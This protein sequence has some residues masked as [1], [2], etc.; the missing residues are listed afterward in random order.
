MSFAMG[1]QPS[2]WGTAANTLPHSPTP[3]STNGSSFY[4]QPLDDL[5]QKAVVRASEGTVNLEQLTDNNSE[6]NATFDQERPSA[7][8]QFKTE[9][10]RI[11]RYT[12]TSSGARNTSDPKSWT[13]WASDDGIHWGQIDRR[14]NQT[15]AWRSMT[16]AY[17]IKNPN[18]YAY[19]KITVDQKSSNHPLA[20]SEFQ[21]LGYSGITKG[22][23]SL[24]RELE[25][26]YEL[27]NVTEAEWDHLIRILDQ[28]QSAYKDGNL[29]ASISSMQA[30]VQQINSLLYQ[31][32]ASEKGSG[33][34]LADA[35]AIVNLLSD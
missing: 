2:S 28:A 21:L 32:N 24:K 20:L 16:R 19:Y 14:T 7:R 8:F 1:A 5:S 29:S 35:H 30:A 33:L 6:T 10:P 9:S 12:L 25:H 27:K 26:Q 31:T 17:T 22:F 18:A 34:L 11:K 23:T 15:F 13:L 3:Q 4:P